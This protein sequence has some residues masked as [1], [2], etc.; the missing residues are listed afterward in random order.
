MKSKSILWI[1]LLSVVLGL[2]VTYN[3]IQKAESRELQKSADE[4]KNSLLE[5]SR[6]RDSLV[7]AND[8]LQAVIAKYQYVVDSLGVIDIKNKQK[9][10]WLNKELGKA[11]VEIEKMSG[12]DAYDDVKEEYSAWDNIDVSGTYTFDEAEVKEIYKD[13]VRVNYLD[14]IRVVQGEIIE[15]LEYGMSLKEEIITALKKDNN[16]KLNL[17]KKLYNDKEE[18]IIKL[19]ASEA[20]NERLRKALRMW[21]TGALSGGAALV[22]IL[23]LL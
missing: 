3:L 4:L 18:L 21:Q 5:L 7:V 10:N 12:D 22:L 6:H 16:D 14:S 20:D 23:L 2:S 15:S 19:D 11:L 13:A 8:S 9:I 17:I 1:S